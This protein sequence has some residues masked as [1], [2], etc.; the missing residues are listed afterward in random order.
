MSDTSW[1]GCARPR[2]ASRGRQARRSVSAPPGLSGCLL[3]ALLG[4]SARA[5]D[6]LTPEDVARLREVSAAVIAPDGRHIAYTLRVPRTPDE[7]ANGPAW[8]ELH[9]TDPA[10]NSRG[11][12][13]GKVNV[14]NVNWLPDS[15]M[16]SFTAKL[17]DEKHTGLYVIP[18]DGGQARRLSTIKSD[19]EGYA[20]SPDGRHVALLAKAPRSDADEEREKSGY[21][22]TVY[23]EDWRCTRVFIT[24]L[25]NRALDLPGSAFDVA[26]S[27]DGSRLAVALAAT[28]GPDAEMMF[29]RLAIVDATRGTITGDVQR[30]GKL[31]AFRFAPDSQRI[32]LIAAADLHDPSDGRLLVAP[33]AG[34]AA[35]ELLPGLLGH[36]R[37]LAWQNPETLLYLTHEGCGCTVGKVTADGRAQKAFFRDPA[38]FLHGLSLSADGA[39]AA[40]VGDAP[41]HPSEVC[42][43]RK[44]GAGPVRLTNS[45][46]WLA[47]RALGRQ[48]V[49]AY[50]ARDGLEIQGPLIYPLDHDPAR[51]YPL[52]VVV[53]GGPEAHFSNQW[54]T[55]YS[56]LGQ[57]FAARG[58]FAFFPNYRGSTGRGVAFSQ[59]DHRDLAGREFDDLVDGVEHLASLGL[60]DRAR[61]GITGGSY[62]GYATAWGATK[63]TQH[64]AAGVMSVGLTDLTSFFGTTDIPYEM[65]YVHARVWP[66]EDPA[67][68][69]ERSPLTYAAQARTPLL[70]LHG[71]ADE[72]VHP[73][74]SLALYRYLKVLGKTPVRLVLYPGEGHGNQKAAARYDYS[75]R[76]LQWMEHYL[77]SPGQR[78][79]PPPEYAL[80]YKLRW[81]AGDSDPD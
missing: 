75:L 25:E 17:N 13:T 58:F 48:E 27:P 35:R 54:L 61:V 24:G 45:N 63:L 38:V 23:E 43:W 6:P 62:G 41:D 44:S 4:S 79:T 68:F 57:V 39:T 73:S 15:S 8:S 49:I 56:R 51:T 12:V 3:L 47:E 30:V 42:V 29:N 1:N 32:A 34:G 64:F 36:V 10:G 18:I 74:Q 28:P 26:W 66:W 5:A 33:A 37:G 11:F 72:R 76:T 77:K 16:I 20:F 80:D 65:Q 69:R 60:I 59:A 21:N 31:G 78:E 50:K 40:F 67:F 55:T 70:I 14:G 53:H 9:V 71:Q 2:G 7:H 52:V 19:V 22:Q 81:K 46:P